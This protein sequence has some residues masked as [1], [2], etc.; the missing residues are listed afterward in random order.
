MQFSDRVLAD[1][2]STYARAQDNRHPL[3]RSLPPPPQAISS[4]AQ[5]PGRGSAAAKTAEAHRGGGSP[6]A[7][8][9]RVKLSLIRNFEYGRLFMC[10]SRVVRVKDNTEM[11]YGILKK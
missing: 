10:R 7:A 4:F 2:L 11:S 5:L 8:L 1:L 9:A 3:P 6:S